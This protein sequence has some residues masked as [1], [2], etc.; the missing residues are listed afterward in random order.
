MTRKTERL[1]SEGISVIVPTFQRPDGIKIALNSL[2]KQHVDNRV[3]EIV[4]ADNDPTGSAREFVTT[5]AKDCPFDV[6]YVHV[7]SRL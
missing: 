7:Q 5:F 1:W 6:I 3:M 4:V 2:K